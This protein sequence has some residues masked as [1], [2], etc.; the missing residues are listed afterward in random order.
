[1]S[2][3]GFE[4]KIVGFLCNWCASNA[5]D[6]AGTTRIQYPPNIRGIRVMCSGSVDPAYILKALLEGA[7]GVL[8]AGCHPGDCHYVSGNYK[9]RRRVT[10]LRTILR[11]LGLEEDRVW[12]K[13]IS[14]SEGKKFAETVDEMVRSVEALGPSPMAKCWSL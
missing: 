5:A 4:P 12:M 11:T 13:W 2:E 7:D 3:N 9:A 8:V 1:M 6:L 10:A 14:A